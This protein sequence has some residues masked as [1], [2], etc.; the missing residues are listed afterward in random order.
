MRKLGLDRLAKI[1]L[2]DQDILKPLQRIKDSRT[3][4][5]GVGMLRIG[6]RNDHHAHRG[7][8]AALV[9]GS[10]GRCGCFD[11]YC[12]VIIT[13]VEPSGTARYPSVIVQALLL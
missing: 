4:C 6:A 8:R 1:A 9:E 7:C 2:A 12:V 10:I 5:V 13:M 11:R 3:G